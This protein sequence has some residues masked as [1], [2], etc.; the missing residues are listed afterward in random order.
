MRESK[1]RVH[2]NLARMK[3][4]GEMFEVDVDPDLAM[5]FKKNVPG[6]DIRE[7]L[8][9]E[10]VFKDAQK[11]LVAS[12]ARLM[13][14]FGT[15]DALEVAAIIIKEGEIQVTS[16]YRSEL[17]ETKRRRIISIIHQNGIDPRTKA[18][19]PVQRIEAALEEAKVRID[20]HKSPEDQV[21]DIVDKLRKVM[22]ITFSKKQ[23]W[24]HVPAVFAVKSQGIVRNMSTIVKE[25]WN[26]DGSWDVTVEIPGGMQEEFY[27]KLNSLTQ[28]MIET[29]ILKE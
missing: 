27:D 14:L 23:I 5:K 29:K 6:V 10:H 8:R 15:D 7:V 3:K 21:Q 12:G 28:G 13:E 4:S 19:H 18:P 16:D 22:P 17:R 2:L 26:N 1:E 9:A 11:G 24:I 25:S 20:E